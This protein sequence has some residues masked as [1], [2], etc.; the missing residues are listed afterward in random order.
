MSFL[1]GDSICVGD[2][3]EAMKRIVSQNARR[4][5]YLD[6]KFDVTEKQISFTGEQGHFSSGIAMDCDTMVKVP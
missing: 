2:Q 1:E 5:Q 3:R 4:S 6:R